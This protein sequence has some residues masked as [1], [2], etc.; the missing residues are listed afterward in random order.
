MD[1]QVINAQQFGLRAA[2]Y[3][4]SS[5]DGKTILNEIYNNQLDIVFITAE[6]L[7]SNNFVSKIPQLRNNYEEEEDDPWTRVPLLVIDEAHC[8]SDWGHD[9]RAAYFTGMKN[10]MAAEWTKKTLR[11]GTSATV[12]MRVHND[13][14]FVLE[15]F[16]L[17]R[18]DLFRDNLAIRVISGARA[19]QD[20]FDWVV[21]Y[22]KKVINFCSLSFNSLV[23][24]K[25]HPNFFGP[26]ASSVKA[27]WP[28]EGTEYFSGRIY[29]RS[30]SGKERG[31]RGS[32]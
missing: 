16:K 25:K 12:P 19:D 22:V 17:V 28:L 29:V 14:K 13:L 27:C 5:I 4:S 30:A 21:K 23:S 15:D 3:N 24:A 6:M 20:K 7:Q 10:V 8:V 26:E 32:I 18:G 31:C 9:F 1:D 11:L 2:T